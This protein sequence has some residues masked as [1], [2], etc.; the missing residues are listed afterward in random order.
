MGVDMRLGRRLLVGLVAAGVV[1]G[2]VMRVEV[3]K[4]G[5]VAATAQSFLV[6]SATVGATDGLP[7]G[8]QHQSFTIDC[9]GAQTSPSWMT[10]GTAPT[11]T[12]GQVT[13]D[14]TADTHYYD[15]QNSVGE[16]C[17][18]AGTGC[19]YVPSNY[20][21]V[22]Q[23]GQTLRVGG[24][25]VSENYSSYQFVASYIW[26][27]GTNVLNPPPLPRPSTV[28]DYDFSHR[29]VVDGSVVQSGSG[30]PGLQLW[31]NQWGIVL[32]DIPT[33]VNSTT[34]TNGYS[35]NTQVEAIAAAHQ[36]PSTGDPQLTINM[37]NAYPLNQA[38]YAVPLTRYWVQNSNG[39]YVPATK[40]DATMCTAAY[41][42]A[43]GQLPQVEVAGSYGWL[44]GDWAFIAEFVWRPA[45]GIQPGYYAFNA[46][47]TLQSGAASTSTGSQDVQ[48]TYTGSSLSGPGDVNPA[49]ITFNTTWSQESSGNIWQFSGDWQATRCVMTDGSTYPGCQ[50][51]GNLSGTFSGTWDPATQVVR[52]DV[53][54]ESG[55]GKFC[56]KTGSGTFQGQAQAQPAGLLA[57][58][59]PPQTLNGSFAIHVVTDST[60]AC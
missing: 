22:I 37:V 13:I 40:Q 48:G 33:A 38:S 41:P 46:D 20:D 9:A 8:S 60:A 43:S 32:G 49:G 16:Y 7:A 11:C 12:N 21:V 29:F 23:P 27:P 36:D 45:P 3:P 53:V 58:A 10:D 51:P 44:N 24:T 55:T 2:V 1:A 54:L 5:A 57:T 25:W 26:N 14:V 34:G 39:Q 56:G 18:S 47:T 4:A 19:Q 30:I 28:Q 31:S 15:S 6:T 52:A 42:C 17:P 59:A 35:G 50:S